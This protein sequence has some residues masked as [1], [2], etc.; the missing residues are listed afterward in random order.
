MFTIQFNL[1]LAVTE[2]EDE[3]EIQ[4]I[5]EQV[6]EDVRQASQGEAITDPN[7]NEI[8]YWHW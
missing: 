7:G 2:L 6:L 4:R 3:E 1:E 8:G 5:L